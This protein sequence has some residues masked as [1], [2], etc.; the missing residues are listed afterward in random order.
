[1]EIN[2]KIKL[3]TLGKIL[4]IRLPTKQNQNTFAGEIATLSGWGFRDTRKK[5][6]PN[7]LY[8]INEEILGNEECTKQ[9]KNPD[10][11]PAIIESEICISTSFG[12]TAC[13]GLW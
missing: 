8:Y 10:R 12:K 1:M 9:N 2:K 3:K 5:N 7:I 11:Y 4:P 6:D 13:P